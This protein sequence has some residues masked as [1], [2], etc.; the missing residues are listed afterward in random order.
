MDPVTHAA[1]AYLLYVAY[2]AVTTRRLPVRW[3][4]VPVA[5]GS[6]FPD[7]IDKPLA[8]WGVIPYGR[9]L[10]HSVF[11]L[12]IVCGVVWWATRSLSVRFDDRVPDSL[13]R[14]TPA[15]FTIGY[16]AHL[17]GDSWQSLLR[18]DLFAV[19]FLAYPLFGVPRSASDSISPWLRVVELYREPAAAMHLEIV[20]AAIVMFV[21][22]RLWA[23]RRGR[24]PKAE[25]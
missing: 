12:V 13:W 23:A 8:F 11:S 19:R 25:R 24:W 1:V 3:A 15:A 17:L 7:L 18:G 16:A 2:A 21:G 9:S 20:A 10:A 6:Q 5:I 4:L 14:V 22:L